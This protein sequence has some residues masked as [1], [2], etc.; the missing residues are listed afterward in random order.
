MAPALDFALYISWYP[1][2]RGSESSPIVDRIV[3]FW[4][5]VYHG[6]IVSNPF[7]A[8][9]DAYIDRSKERLNFSDEFARYGYLDDSETRVLKIHEF[10]GRPVFYYTEYNDIMPLKRAA[11]D[12]AK[13]SHLQYEFMDDH[14]ELAE[15]VFLTRYSDGEEIVTNYSKTPYDWR[16]ISVSPRTNRLFASGKSGDTPFRK[17]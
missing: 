8:T 2:G 5:L 14:R 3:P 11:D 9:I 6:I 12:Y 1:G 15:G 16:G 7:Y 4:Q 10:G 13:F 17:M